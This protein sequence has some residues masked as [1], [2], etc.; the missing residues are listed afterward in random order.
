MSETAARCAICGEPM[1]PGE[2]MFKYHGYSGDCPKPP[3]PK[4][5]PATPWDAVIPEKW[6]FDKGT[7]LLTRGPDE[8]EWIAGIVGVGEL[9]YAKSPVSALAEAIVN[10]HEYGKSYRQ[11]APPPRTMSP[12]R[13]AE[14]R[15]SARVT[16]WQTWAAL[17]LRDAIAE[18]DALRP[19]VARLSA[20]EAFKGSEYAD[21][22]D[23]VVRLRSENAALAAKVEVG[24][25][26]GL[27]EKVQAMAA[28]GDD[29]ID[30]ACNTLDA[31]I[32]DYGDSDLG[33]EDMPDDEMVIRP[34]PFMETFRERIENTDFS[35]ASLAERHSRRF[36]WAWKVDGR[37]ASLYLDGVFSGKWDTNNGTKFYWSG[38]VGGV[39]SNDLNHDEHLAILHGHYLL[40][41]AS[42][43][44]SDAK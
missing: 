14:L 31:L 38:F 20:Y 1:P 41:A 24:K 21:V 35:L 26:E 7:V 36:G 18:I 22:V 11:S 27:V 8:G 37:T 39:L 25:R 6:V 15:E 17:A 13:E 5:V 32:A 19:E 3:L 34:E 42:L 30:T 29:V 12:E 44:G 33:Y 43:G 10:A 2:Q 23:E 16:S 40:T 28:R 4:P 9:A